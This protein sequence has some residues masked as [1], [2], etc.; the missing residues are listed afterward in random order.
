LVDQHQIQVQH[1]HK[2]EENRWLLT[3]FTQLEAVIDLPSVDVTL[4]ISEI[5]RKVNFTKA[6]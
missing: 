4:P 5:Y 6:E 2:L 3:I 1:Y